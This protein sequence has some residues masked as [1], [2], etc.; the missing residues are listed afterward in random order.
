MIAW[1]L[2][3]ILINIF[4]AVTIVY[5]LNRQLTS[6][7]SHRLADAVCIILLAGM[8][9]AYLY[10]DIPIASDTII[11]V[12]PAIYSLIIFESKWYITLF[13]NIITLLIFTGVVNLTSSFYTGV[14]HIEWAR[15]MEITPERFGFIISTN[16]LTLILMII[17]IQVNKQDKNDKL[18]WHS[19]SLLLGL[20]IVCLTAIELLF[21][22]G[23]EEDMDR[24]FTSVCICLF[25][26]SILSVVFYE[27]MARNAHKQRQYE[28]EINRLELT[29]KYNNERQSVYED[30]AVFRHD[31]KHHM[32]VIEQMCANQES[33][34]IKNHLD[35]LK[36][37]FRAIQ[38]FSTGNVAVDA[39]LT[40]KA[41]IMR[42]LGMTF[43]FQAYPLIGIPVSE[44]D[45]CS[46][47]GNALDN[48]IEGAERLRNKKERTIS[49]SFARTWDMFFIVCE[50]PFDPDTIRR[51]DGRWLSSKKGDGHGLGT[52]S[53]AEVVK[54][55]NGTVSYETR[56]NTF[57]TTIV[58][59]C[60]SQEDK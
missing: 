32:Q 28:V 41:S 31:I 43:Q 51:T 45:L 30:I 29:N 59:P 11:F 24:R 47:L 10:F 34:E 57:R 15:L 21:T 1:A 55:A 58:F 13:W 12:I 37:Q 3:E 26:I 40:A 53:I 8:L 4:Q 2:F 46:L 25:V 14:L 9:T 33:S 50:N 56:G 49:L 6:G 22:I 27:M 52:R 5:F 20:N 60:R 18:S 42:H 38:P 17:L 35:A 23:M 7:H 44:N 36:R 54:K 19:F 39:L 48:A 16:M